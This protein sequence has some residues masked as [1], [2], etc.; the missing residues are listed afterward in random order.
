MT[1][2][3]IVMFSCDVMVQTDGSQRYKGGRPTEKLSV[4]LQIPFMS[5]DQFCVTLL[6]LFFF[7]PVYSYISFIREVVFTN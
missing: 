7:C 3:V 2:I 4:E 6:L 1:S 5:F